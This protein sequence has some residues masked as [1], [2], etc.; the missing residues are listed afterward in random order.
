MFT[1]IVQNQG[2]VIRRKKQGGQ[3]HFSFRLIKK[4]KRKIEAGESIAVDGVCLTAR[5]PSSRNFEADVIRETLEATTLGNL[6]NGNRVNIERSLRLGDSLGG[7][8]VTGHVDGTGQIVQIKSLGRNK[9]FS[10]KAPEKALLFLAPKG[11]VTVDGIS[12]TLQKVKGT[13]FEVGIVPHTLQE[14]TFS[15]KKSGDR[16]NLEADLIARYLNQFSE[17]RDKSALL[18]LSL[19]RKKQGKALLGRLKKQGF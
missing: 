8:F 16:V 12:L 7:H 3:A 19:N 14:T 2:I 11:S 17:F 9:T 18:D 6:R 4:E 13:V 15:R 10:I 5:A 1:G